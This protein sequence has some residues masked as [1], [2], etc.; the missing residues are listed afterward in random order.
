MPFSL[1]SSLIL[2]LDKIST[3]C[4]IYMYN[5]MY[6]EFVLLNKGQKHSFLQIF[7]TLV[8]RLPC[9]RL[10]AWLFICNTI[11]ARNYTV[12]LRNSS[13]LNLSKGEI[14]TSLKRKKDNKP[15]LT[16]F[17]KTAAKYHQFMTTQREQPWKLS[18][19]RYSCER[20]FLTHTWDSRALPIWTVGS[21]GPRVGPHSFT[22]AIFFDTGSLMKANHL[23]R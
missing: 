2:Y 6:V 18:L 7:F 12:S 13:L 4:Y 23:F 9:I 19:Q 16:S 14:A 3:K 11:L 5:W 21:V 8:V 15:L 17:Y 10:W 22:R 20:S 1:F